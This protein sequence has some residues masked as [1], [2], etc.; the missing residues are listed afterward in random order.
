MET[1]ALSQSVRPRC[2]IQAA[3]CHWYVLDIPDDRGGFGRDLALEGVGIGLELLIGGE[4][5]AHV[6]LVGG[7]IAQ[8][9][10]EDL[11]DA[12]IAPA[13]GMAAGVPLV[14]LAGHRDAFGVGRPDGEAHAFHPIGL[15][16]VRAQHAI[17]FVVRALGVQVQLKIGDERAEAVGVFELDGGAVPQL[18]LKQILAGR[19]GEGG[20]EEAA[21][22]SLL[23]GVDLVADAQRGGFGL[24]QEGADF[25]AGLATAF[26]DGVRAEDTEGIAV[27]SAN[28]GFDFFWCHAKDAY[29][30][31]AERNAWRRLAAGA[32][33][34][35]LCKVVL[36]CA[37]LCVPRAEFFFGQTKPPT[38]PVSDSP[39]GIIGLAA[40]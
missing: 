25:P 23:H 30:C 11:P 35:G 27:V 9:G 19:A 20:A 1:G 21:V 40:M 16:E 12:A 14:E 29:Y 39:C 18:G 31:S 13:H 8:F 34:A 38:K 6:V 2:S 15:G 26:A 28:Y 36:L 17:G 37:F 24:R 32:K 5:R 22:V 7:A 4:A 10:D 3:S 33:V